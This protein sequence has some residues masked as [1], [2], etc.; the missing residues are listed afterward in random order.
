MNGFWRSPSPWPGRRCNA[1]DGRKRRGALHSRCFLSP[2]KAGL[3]TATRL[4]RHIRQWDLIQCTCPNLRA[5]VDSFVGCH[6]VLALFQVIRSPRPRNDQV[7]ENK[8]PEG[9][10][11]ER[12]HCHPQQGAPWTRSRRLRKQVPKR[13]HPCPFGLRLCRRPHLEASTSQKQGTRHGHTDKKERRVRSHAKLG[14]DQDVENTRMD[15]EGP[16]PRTCLDRLEA[17]P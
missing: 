2:R 3:L 9:K 17:R 5:S 6:L 4:T 12:I 14:L 10:N 1:S 8:R 13:H 16:P 7:Q 11:G 15:G